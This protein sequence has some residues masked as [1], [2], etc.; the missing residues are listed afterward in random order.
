MLESWS[1]KKLL[2]IIT[3]VVINFNV[4]SH[5]GLLSSPQEKCMDKVIKWS[6]QGNKEDTASAAIVCRGANKGTDKCMESVVKNS[7]QGNKEDYVS[8]AII[9]LGN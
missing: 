4:N 8:A 3:F 7:Y 5:A 2:A 1:M 9:C 6:Y